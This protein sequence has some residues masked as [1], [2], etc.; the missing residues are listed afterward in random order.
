MEKCN[1]NIAIIEPSHI[2]YEGL[3][4][5]LLKSVKHFNLYRLNDFDELNSEP[6]KGSIHIVIINPS[7][8]QNRLKTFNKLK[9]SHPDILWIGLL[10]S[11]F[12]NELLHVFNDTISISDAIEVITEKLNKSSNHCHGNDI[13][14]E[15]LSE[16]EID[17]LIELVKGSLNKEIAEK[18]NISVHT[19]VS[20]R[21]R[22]IKKTGIK[23]LSGLTIYAISKKIM[24][25]DTT[26]T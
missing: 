14:Q 15:Q 2:I 10:Y 13:S 19:V 21:K 25:L 22:I 3:S 20:H 11:Y 1:I 17:V 12:D 24:P 5:L 4:T 6:L 7:L 23:S 8:V 26:V 9:K 18:L 16:R